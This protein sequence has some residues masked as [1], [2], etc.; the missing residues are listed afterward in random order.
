MKLLVHQ[1]TDEILFL[2]D[3]IEDLGRIE[4]DQND[5]SMYKLIYHE[6]NTPEEYY[7]GKCY[8]YDTGDDPIINKELMEANL[9]GEYCIQDGNIILKPGYA[10]TEIK[11]V[12]RNTERLISILEVNQLELLYELSL[13]QLGI[14][15]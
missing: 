6:K 13:L 15:L 12:K 7:K 11:S 10:M 5:D 14:I 4:N 8:I 3:D 1:G 2:A 9:P